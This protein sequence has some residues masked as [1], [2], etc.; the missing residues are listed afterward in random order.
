MHPKNNNT[1]ILIVDDNLDDLRQLGH[2]LKDQGEI[3][4]ATSGESG[5][6][7]AQKHKPDLVIAE[8][9]L[10]DIPG[11][12]LCHR[13]KKQRDSRHC[14]VVLVSAL[15]SHENELNALEAGAL[16]FICK[17][18]SSPIVKARIKN[19]AL[20]SREQNL[21]HI[22]AN[23]DGLTGVYNRRY[24]ENQSRLEIKRHY[25]QQHPLT[26]ALLDIDHFKCFNDAYGHLQGDICLK[27]VAQA[28]FTSSRRPGEFVARYGGEEF[29][30]I[31]PNTDISD[32]KKY[33]QWICERILSLAIPHTR[34]EP[35]PFVSIS[36]G[37]V[38]VIPT[39][40][41]SIE[42]M[43]NTADSA[44]YLAKESGRNQFKAATIENES[45]QEA[46]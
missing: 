24:F 45:I 42:N 11:P 33:G 22:L 28:L 7:M 39:N 36:I 37:I 19:H 38:S 30:V 18:Y 34:S 26:L 31:L 44:L 12:A 13:L 15:N 3:L 35:V 9:N 14:N 8:L 17:P 20:Q 23:K 32:A 4:F 27:E 21:L 6:F 46:I 2:L 25:R 1:L 40:H 43:I 5:L 41:T 10:R 29:A 16:D